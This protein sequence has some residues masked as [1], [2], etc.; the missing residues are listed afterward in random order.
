MSPF[1]LS[2]VDKLTKYFQ[3]LQEKQAAERLA[4]KLKRLEDRK[5]QLPPEEELKTKSSFTKYRSKSQ[6]HL[7]EGNQKYN[8]DDDIH[9]PLDEEKPGG[10]NYTIYE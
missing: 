5:I 3:E 8:E 7:I 2:R 1:C 9:D 4:A 6:I 10:V